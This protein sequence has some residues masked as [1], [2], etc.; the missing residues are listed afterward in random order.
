MLLHCSEGVISESL[1]TETSDNSSSSTE[2]ESSSIASKNQP[3]SGD[4]SP[5]SSDDS[6]TDNTDESSSE[7]G[8]STNENT[9][10]S[11]DSSAQKGSE[12]SSSSSIDYSHLEPNNYTV[13]KVT[14]WFNLDG[15]WGACLDAQSCSSSID[16]DVVTFEFKY[17]GKSDWG[18]KQ[19]IHDSK[20]FW[21]HRH[22]NGYTIGGATQIEFQ[23]KADKP[24]KNVSFTGI[25]DS[26]R[27]IDL[28]SSYQDVIIPIEGSYEFILSPFSLSIVDADDDYTVS[29]KNIRYTSNDAAH[30]NNYNDAYDE[31]TSGAEDYWQDSAA[32][33]SWEEV[34]SDDFDG[35]NID[36]EKWNILIGRGEKGDGWGN[37]NKD[38]SS[39]DSRAVFVEGGKLV[40]NAFDITAEKAE[41]DA[42]TPPASLLSG[43]LTTKNK[44]HFRYGRF[45]A[46]I[47]MP[48]NISNYMPRSVWPAFWMLGINDMDPN[49]GWPECGELDITE[50]GGMLPNVTLSTLIGKDYPAS[51][52]GTSVDKDIGQNI[53][54]DFHIYEA[55]WDEHKVS[56]YFDDE[57]LGDVSHSIWS[58]DQSFYILL[59]F[60]VGGID[61]K[62]YGRKEN[63]PK[64]SDFPAQMEIDWV[65]VEQKK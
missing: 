10:N 48:L 12:D 11:D 14:P 41:D 8:D 44:A 5:Q 26:E 33:G 2:T 61:A 21:N 32:T 38:F 27:S 55:Q 36:P 35:D 16:G 54:N 6:T 7:N 46:S 49:I 65:T 22:V 51:E 28:T 17:D 29:L 64:M 57:H 56:F 4:D 62:F 39:R 25:N 31:P 13:F 59:N 58:F 1:S 37:G 60:A 40:I 34:W 52:N 43:R 20:W 15:G 47:K 30:K 63:D 9:S 42:A 18:G 24:I 3:S 53:G 19:F 23:V 45:R 50:V